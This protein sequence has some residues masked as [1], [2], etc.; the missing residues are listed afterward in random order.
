VG[1]L[2]PESKHAAALCVDGVRAVAEGPFLSR[3]LCQTVTYRTF[4]D[5]TLPALA[6]V[7]NQVYGVA[8]LWRIGIIGDST[9]YPFRITR[10]IARWS[11]RKP[12]FRRRGD[13]LATDSVLSGAVVHEILANYDGLWAHQEPVRFA[14]RSA[15]RHSVRRTRNWPFV[16]TEADSNMLC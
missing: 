4:A 8:N 5:F 14:R 16:G 6:F 15:G 2:E 9:R 11:T 13:R 7:S 10:P 1:G 12:A 3:G